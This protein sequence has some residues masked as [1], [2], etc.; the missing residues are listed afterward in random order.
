MPRLVLF[1]IDGTLVSSRT[2]RGAI[3]RV[4]SETHG[5]PVEVTVEECAGRPDPQIVRVVLRRLGY[6]ERRI[7]AMLPDALE[8]YLSALDEV[9]TAGTASCHPGVQELLERLSTEPDVTLAL[10]TGNLERGAR[11]K[12]SRF[13]LNRFFPFGAFGSDAE[14]R[15]ALPPIAV[16]RA[17]ARTGIPFR[18]RDVVV[19][20]DTAHDI[21]CGRPYGATCIAVATGPVPREIL[22]AE[23]PDLL[24]DTLEP[25]PSLLEAV[26]GRPAVRLAC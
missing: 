10:L 25:S 12:L 3:S 6:D 24:V 23:G 4:L 18:G 17:L 21:R 22:E 11:I 26:L 19:I 7:D 15:A 1:D 8:G 20:G 13:D 14:E 5:T 16:A 9:Y 2:G